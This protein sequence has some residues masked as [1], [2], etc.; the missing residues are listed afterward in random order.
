MVKNTQKST[1]QVNCPLK[2]SSP[3]FRR[4]KNNNLVFG[5]SDQVRY[6]LARVVTKVSERLGHTKG[7]LKSKQ[8][9]AKKLTRL[10]S[11]THRLICAWAI[12]I[13]SQAWFTVSSPSP[14][15][16]LSLSLFREIKLKLI[17]YF[18]FKYAN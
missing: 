11:C 3:R 15:L 13:C 6:K 8:R 7:L 14:P 12:C 9:I 2:L 1:Y 4:E 17:G 5:V 18:G 10:C 16:S